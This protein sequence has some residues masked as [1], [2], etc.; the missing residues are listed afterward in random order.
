MDSIIWVATAFEP[1]KRY[2]QT[3]VL[4]ASGTGTVLLLSDSGTLHS[5]TRAARFVPEPVQSW[6]SS[7]ELAF[8]L[9]TNAPPARSGARARRILDI[10]ISFFHSA[11]AR[12]V[13]V[14]RPERRARGPC[15]DKKSLSLRKTMNEGIRRTPASDNPP[16]WPHPSLYGEAG[17]SD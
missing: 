11:D 2:P 14:Q 8:P 5:M 6:T 13:V 15:G 12:R 9:R 16:G 3:M 17:H 1:L 10:L 4:S 7:N